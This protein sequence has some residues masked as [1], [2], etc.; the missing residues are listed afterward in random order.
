MTDVTFADL[1]EEL[2]ATER[3]YVVAAREYNEALEAL[4]AACT[5]E[6]LVGGNEEYGDVTWRVCVTCG[7]Y[8]HRGYNDDGD[9]YNYATR[10]YFKVLPTDKGRQRGRR[11]YE[12]AD[13]NKST[14]LHKFG[15]SKIHVPVWGPR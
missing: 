10:A 9:E 5:H 8:E 13:K 15:R 3:E 6:T 4:Q 1:K 14:E 11:A 2:A 12:P 7:L